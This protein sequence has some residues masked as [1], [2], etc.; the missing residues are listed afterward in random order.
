MLPAEH[1]ARL[2]KL[3]RRTEILPGTVRIRMLCIPIQEDG[4]TAKQKLWNNKLL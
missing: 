3:S 2:R 4:S 1:S